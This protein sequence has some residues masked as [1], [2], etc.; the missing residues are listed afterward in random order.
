VPILGGVAC[1][2]LAVYQGFAV[3]PAGSITFLWLSAGGLLFLLLFARKARIADVSSGAFDP[4]LLRLR[5]RSPLVLVPIANPESAPG[6]IAV[7]GALAPPGVGRVLALSVVIA[8]EGWSP[9]ADPRPL[10]NLQRVLGETIAAA[11]ASGSFPETLATIAPQPW[12]EIGR[13]ARAHRCESLLLGLSK[14]EENQAQSPLE[15]LLGRVDCDVVILRAPRGWQL[16]EARRILVPKRGRGGHDELLARLLGSLS[17]AQEREVTFLAVLPER[18]DAA[19]QRSAARSL[20]RT[21][22]SLLNRR[23]EVRVACS[24]S[25]ADR[26]AADSAGA[27]LLILGAQRLGRRRKFFGQFALQ[28]ARRTTTPLLLICHRG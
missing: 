24:D 27:D 1:L 15:E 9:A 4:E 25:P 13:V 2:A 21:A 14:L 23:H 8:P 7:A 6:L 16:P 11:V 20:R 26:V 5:G 17:R 22:E 10:E 18:A 12:R 3:P 19:Q 28:V